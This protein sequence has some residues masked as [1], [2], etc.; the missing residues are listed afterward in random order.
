MIPP[1]TPVI[2]SNPASPGW[3][4]AASPS[5][6][7]SVTAQTPSWIRRSFDN[8]DMEVSQTEHIRKNSQKVKE[9]SPRRPLPSSRSP[10]N[11]ATKANKIKNKDHSLSGLMPPRQGELSRSMVNLS[12]RGLGSRA[13]SKV[14]RKLE[15]KVV[16]VIGISETK[17]TP[18]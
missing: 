17:G 2:G 11:V 7:D 18:V 14:S 8:L 12:M 10:T 5:L 16:N 13:K 15:E 1:S 6:N 3:N 4:P 9:R